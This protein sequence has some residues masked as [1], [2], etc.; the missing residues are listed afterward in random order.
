MGRPALGRWL[1][2]CGFAAA[3]G[4]AWATQDPAGFAAW[5]GAIIPAPALAL[6]AL[7]FGLAG[8]MLL[9]TARE[10]P[11]PPRRAGRPPPAGPAS[12]TVEPEAGVETIRRRLREAE[13][14]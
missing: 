9:R 10:A 4:T 14:E 6:L 2:I 13:K 12:P 3:I 5:T 1:I 8:A 11:Q 7:A